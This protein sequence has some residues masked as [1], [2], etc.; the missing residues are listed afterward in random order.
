[1]QI[2]FNSHELISLMSSAM[3]SSRMKG[4]LSEA[5]S[6]VAF[7]LLHARLSYLCADLGCSCLKQG[8]LLLLL[9]RQQKTVDRVKR[10]QTSLLGLYLIETMT[11][12]EAQLLKFY[13]FFLFRF[14]LR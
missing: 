3:L 9:R 5:H 13:F 4:V 8:L 12:Q 1:M 11:L 6:Q 7:L 10:L 2:A 14:I